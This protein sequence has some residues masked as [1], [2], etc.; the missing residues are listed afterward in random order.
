MWEE[1]QVPK[2]LKDEVIVTIFKNGDRKSCGNY[3]GIDILFIMGK[4]FVRILLH[5]S[6]SRFSQNLGATSVPLGT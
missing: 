1:R 3:R 2:D 6:L 5:H 4:I